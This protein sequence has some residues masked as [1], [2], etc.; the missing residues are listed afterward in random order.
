MQNLK[1][2]NV[3]R[4]LKKRDNEETSKERLYVPS[5]RFCSVRVDRGC[6]QQRG[7]T[8]AGGERGARKGEDEQDSVAVYSKNEKCERKE[9]LLESDWFF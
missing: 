2:E 1:P 3:F 4:L 6:R 8:V 7:S 9:N 5:N